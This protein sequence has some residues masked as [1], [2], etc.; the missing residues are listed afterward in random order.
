MS[1][2]YLE[3]QILKNHIQRQNVHT[4]MSKLVPFPYLFNSLHTSKGGGASNLLEMYDSL[5]SHVFK[6]RGVSSIYSS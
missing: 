1:L 4:R 5:I 2:E 6:H 3:L